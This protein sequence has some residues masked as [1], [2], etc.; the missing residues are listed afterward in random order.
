ME[1]ASDPR[2]SP[3]GE[4]VVYVRRSM[5]I[6][7]DRPN[8]DLWIIGTNGQGHRPI[9]SGADSYGSPRWSPDGS[10]LAYVSS[11]EGRGPQI[12]VRWMD[13]GQTAVLSNLRNSPS[14]LTWSPDGRQL[15]FTQFVPGESKALAAPPPKPEGAEWAPPVKVFDTLPF[16]A[17]GQG[18]LDVGRDHVFVISAE[19]G[20]PRQLTSGDFDHGGRLAWHPDG[21]AIIVAANRQD[22]AEHDPIESELWSIDLAS[23]AMAALTDR[24]GPDAAPALS[25][26]GKTL[27][28]L[29]YD[30]KLMGYENTAVYVMSLEDGEPRRISGDFDRSIDDVQWAGNSRSLLVQ[31]D[32]HGRTHIASL[33]MD[34]DIDSLAD[35][36]GGAILGRPYTSGSFTV[37][38]DGNYAYTAGRPDRPADVGVGRGNREPRRITAL[39]EDALGHKELAKIE[40]INWASSADGLDIQGWVAYPPGFDA[41]KKY[42]LILEIHG[43]PRAAYGP[44]FS[45]EIQLFAAAGYVV[46]YA[47]PRGSTSYGYDFVNEIHHNYPSADYDDLMSGVDAVIAKGFIDED[48]LF[49]TGGSG[50]GLLT[51][52]IVGKTDRF[53]AAVSAKPV[54]NWVSHVLTADFTHFFSRY[55]FEKMPWEDPETYWA[56]SPLSLVGNVTTPTALLTGESDVRTPMTESE[57]FYQALKLR[58]VDTALIRVPEAYHGIVARPSHLIAKVDNILAWFERYR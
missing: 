35:D 29:G 53:A 14:S 45:P 16:Q 26:D 56:Q 19:G 31:Y 32:D 37:A 23:G 46:L 54:I 3:N 9:L 43:G 21:K 41:S 18:F 36:V 57:Q 49:V 30:D 28:W 34:G 7:T 38:R 2:I 1:V 15:A 48:Q 22:D 52:W 13:T 25:P 58:K 44:Q 24:N 55:W 6:M 40:E 42:P 4:Q 27:A 17:D 47:N 5:D 33:S 12:H 8:G 20:T 10:R 51:A 11:V 50:G 39:N